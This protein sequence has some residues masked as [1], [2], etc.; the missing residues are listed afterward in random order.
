MP[1]VLGLSAALLM[2]ATATFAAPPTTP[3]AVVVPDRKG[4][5]SYAREVADILGAK[6]VG[7]HSGARTEGKL[8]LEDVAGMLKGGKRGPAIV[9]GKADESLLFKLAAHRDEPVMPPRA[10]KEQ[11]PLTPE[12]LGLLKL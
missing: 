9:A 11:A 6:C 8:D 10:R 12:E 1:D 2:T 5:V 4:P 3:I 7:C